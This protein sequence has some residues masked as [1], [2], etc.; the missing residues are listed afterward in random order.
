MTDHSTRRFKLS[1]SLPLLPQFAMQRDTNIWLPVRMAR[2][3]THILATQTSHPP[4]DYQLQ[5]ISDRFSI[6]AMINGLL[7]GGDSSPAHTYSMTSHR[8]VVTTLL[9]KVDILLQQEN[10]AHK[11]STSSIPLMMLLASTAAADLRPVNDDTNLRFLQDLTLMLDSLSQESPRIP[12]NLNLSQEG[13]HSAVKDFLTDMSN[14]SALE[15]I[16][17]R[18]L[19]RLQA[20]YVDSSPNVNLLTSTG[21]TTWLPPSPHNHLPQDRDHPTRASIDDRPPSAKKPSNMPDPA[22]GAI[23]HMNTFFFTQAVFASWLGIYSALSGRQQ[24]LRLLAATTTCSLGPDDILVSY[25]VRQLENISL[26]HH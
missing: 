8:L 16:I 12:E 15:T 19:K 17:M 20:L 5:S 18:C 3:V 10:H 22:M 2:Y 24:A 25:L 23:Q 13:A 6:P 7:P 9:E 4:H 21:L 14:K 1:H 26:W 11:D